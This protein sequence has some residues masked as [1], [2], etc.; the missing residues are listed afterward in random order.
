MTSSAVFSHFSSKK[1]VSFTKMNWMIYYAN[2][3]SLKN[4]A[5]KIKPCLLLNDQ[6]YLLL[7]LVSHMIIIWNNN[8]I[9]KKMRQKG[10]HY[11][12]LY[13]IFNTFTF[14]QQQF[15]KFLLT[16]EINR[17]AIIVI[18]YLCQTG[19]KSSWFSRKILW[20]RCRN[21]YCLVLLSLSGRLETMDIS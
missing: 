3:Q 7:F 1:Y 14:V 18:L 13:C 20:E 17:N 16:M 21:L 8:H 10:V 5:G 15:N 19:K 9:P 11:H 6:L 2:N 12:I 4:K